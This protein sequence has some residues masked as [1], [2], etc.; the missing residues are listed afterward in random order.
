MDQVSYSLF[1]RDLMGFRDDQDV[2]VFIDV[3]TN[4]IAERIKWPRICPICKT[5][6]N[7]AFAHGVRG[8]RRKVKGI[9]SEMRQ[10]RVFGIRWANYVR[11]VPGNFHT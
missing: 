5:S 4:V 10:P 9:L 3:P 2:M 1:F 6:R 11:F 7:Q 8:I